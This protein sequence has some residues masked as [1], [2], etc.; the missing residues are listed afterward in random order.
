[1]R[2][3]FLELRLLRLPLVRAFE[4]SFGRVASRT[5][6][7]VTVRGDG[8]EGWGESVADA[9]PLYSGETTDTVWRAIDAYLAPRLLAA[10]L[11]HPRE[12]G[13]RFRAVRGHHMA[14][15]AVEMAVWDLHARRE[16]RPLSALLG[17]VR[18]AVP[19]GVSIGIEASIE[20]L[21]ERIAIER[22]AGYQRVKI[23]IKP[24]WDA[25]V[26]E[27]VRARFGDDLPLMVDAN[28]AY[29]PGDAAL[30]AL[31][32]Q[33]LLMI[34]QP[35]AEDDLVEHAALQR[36][37]RTPICLDESIDTP[38]DMAAALALGACRVVN[39]KP[40]R[41]GGH[42]ASIAVH[43]RCAA[44]GVP[45]WHGGMLETGIGRAH[46]LHLAS[47]PQF[48]LPGD[49][50]ASERYFQPDLIEPPIR[51][52]A[53]GTIAVPTGPGIGVT[54]VPERVERATER[55]LATTA[56]AAARFPQELGSH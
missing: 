49:I 13:E 28:A 32:A 56:R 9:D 53:D 36:R 42:A 24:G 47:L 20:G 54:I 8:L 46:N 4:T 23:K 34:E 6:V 18:A 19:S 15:A 1:M 44:A 43:D 37:L 38:A 45:V 50:A 29:Q 40:G 12:L 21:L 14:K 35:L 52:A 48:T 27:R 10:P 55:R 2:I 26:V 22:A 11:S 17:G 39:I 33:G 5:I 3:D 30:D 41:L 16:G 51:V 7:L 25:A 31:D